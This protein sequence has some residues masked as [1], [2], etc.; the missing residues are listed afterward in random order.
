MGS[1]QTRLWGLPE[2]CQGAARPGPSAPKGSAT[3]TCSCGCLH[4]VMS[5]EVATS[6]LQPARRVPS[7]PPCRHGRGQVSRP[8][9]GPRLPQG[10][11]HQTRALSRQVDE[12]AK[13]TQVCLG[14]FRGA[15]GLGPG[16][17][18]LCACTGPLPPAR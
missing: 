10:G 6:R 5:T 13:G 15:G 18:C 14:R 12:E 9:A 1:V 7:A 16:L 4:A 17:S 11:S 3:P 2:L 8:G